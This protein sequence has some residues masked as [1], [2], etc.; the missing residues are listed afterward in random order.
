MRRG[1]A[2]ISPPRPKAKRIRTKTPGTIIPGASIVVS[3]G[4]LLV[5]RGLGG[6]QLCFFSF[7]MLDALTQF[8]VL[9]MCI[10]KLFLKLNSRFFQYH[11]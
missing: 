9:D 4:L 10:V 1:A 8:F 11:D 3:A 5:D 2:S 7:Q 6:C